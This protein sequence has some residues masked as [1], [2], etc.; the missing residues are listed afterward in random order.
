MNTAMFAHSK[1]IRPM[2]IIP[3]TRMN[4][5]M[6]G[7]GTGVALSIVYSLVSNRNVILSAFILF[8]TYIWIQALSEWFAEMFSLDLGAYVVFHIIIIEM[9]WNF[10]KLH[11]LVCIG[12]HYTKECIHTYIIMDS[13]TMS[14]PRFQRNSWLTI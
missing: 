7:V 3:I 10:M 11:Q 12:L 1:E 9:T 2:R 6:A 13:M 5:Y 14:L 8:S 4:A